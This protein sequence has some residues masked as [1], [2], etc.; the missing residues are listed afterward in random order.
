MIR[1]IIKMEN[2]EN[3]MYQPRIGVVSQHSL[4]DW[5]FDEIDQGI[6]LTWL[7]AIED[8]KN[9][10][11]AENPNISEDDLEQRIEEES[12]N[13]EF[14][15][16]IMLFGDWKVNEEGKYEIDREGEYGF[17]AEYN[18]DTGNIC[19]EYSKYIMINS[20]KTSPCYIQADDGH[21]C[22]DLDSEGSLEGFSLPPEYY[23]ED[24]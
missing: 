22:A 20:R 6:D 16:R 8:L 12:E 15:R 11:K 17:S 21:P 23:R 1:K 19:V 10:I 7:E 14:N 24:D 2:T 5:I 4:A 18:N 9:E 13:F 3:S